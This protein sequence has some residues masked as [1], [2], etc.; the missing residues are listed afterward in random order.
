MF[1]SLTVPVLHKGLLVSSLKLSTLKD[2]I[3]FIIFIFDFVYLFFP[4]LPEDTLGTHLI[5]VNLSIRPP[6]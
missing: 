4:C 1:L 2:Y 5:S 6:C 3:L